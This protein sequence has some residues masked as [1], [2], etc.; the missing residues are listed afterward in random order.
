MQMC[1]RF[2]FVI[3]HATPA[4]RARGPLR[5]PGAAYNC[6]LG[7]KRPRDD[8]SQL[9]RANRNREPSGFDAAIDA[10]ICLVKDSRGT[11]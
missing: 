4:S 1:F 3:E 10:N 8:F 6:W 11:I 9:N 2:S 7:G 5:D